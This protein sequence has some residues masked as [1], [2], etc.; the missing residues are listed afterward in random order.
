[1]KSIVGFKTRGFNT[2]CPPP[3]EPFA[4]KTL[5]RYPEP[6]WNCARFPPF[7]IVTL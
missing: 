1:M 5:P 6:F 7:G 2:A 4:F 3:T